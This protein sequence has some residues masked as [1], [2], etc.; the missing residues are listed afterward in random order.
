LIAAC[1]DVGKVSPGFQ[2]KYFADTVVARYAPSLVGRIGF[3]DL[4]ADIGA[5]A[6]DKYL[7]ASLPGSPA[8]KAIAAHHGTS[9]RVYL[10]DTAEPLG[11]QLWSE[12]RQRLLR[13]LREIFEGELEETTDTQLLSGLVCVSDWIGSSEEFFPS[14]RASALSA[15]SASSARLA[16]AQCGFRKFGFLK[17]LSFEQV[18][19]FAPR[20]AQRDFFENI[21]KPG[22]YILEAPM[23]IGKT[24]AALYA[25][26]KLM[27][28]GYNHGLYFA[29]P[30]RLTSDRIHER[31]AEFLKSIVDSNTPPE[32]LLAH[33]AAW[34]RSYEHGGVELS[35]G[36][37]WFFPAKRAL[38]HP[39]AVG[40]L[41]QALLG[42][43][44]VRHNF[45][46]LFGLAGKVVILDEVHSYDVY[47]GTLLDELTKRLREIGC[48][49]IILSATLTHHR[50]LAIAP[51][52]QVLPM[53]NLAESYPL[54]STS[55]QD[56]PVQYKPLP[57]PES[58]TYT[59]R[60]A[61]WDASALADF[62]IE[63]AQRGACVVCI[64]NTVAKAQIWYKTI[65]ATLRENAFPIGILHS[66]FPQ[67]RREEI[68]S[69]W[70]TRL[71]R[72]SAMRPRGAIMVATQ[73][74]E[75]SVDI[76]A[77]LMITE[78]APTD[79]ILQRMG[80]LWRHKRSNRPTAGPE[81]IIISRRPEQTAEVSEII[82]EIGA[83]NC[84]VYS[85]YI[86]MRSLAV[87][88]SRDT[89]TLPND[90]RPLI[91]ATYS[92]CHEEPGSSMY[93]LKEML[94]DQAR[95]LRSLAS[96]AQSSAFPAAS[97]R[98]E[99]RTRYS[100][101]PTVT[102]LLLEAI[103]SE[104]GSEDTAL[105]R[106]LDGTELSLNEYQRNLSSTRTLH[107]W[108]VSI[109][110]YLLAAPNWKPP[111]CRW[112]RRHFHEAPAVLIRDSDSA[113][114]FF[115]NG[116]ETKLYYSD[117]YGICRAENQERVVSSTQTGKTCCPELGD[118]DF[119]DPFTS[120]W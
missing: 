33:G 30:T 3:N 95:R 29:L 87:W 116:A 52:F 73:V 17:N 59:S 79:M 69:E 7:G 81:C 82:E 11:G 110:K 26:Y 99:G 15:D 67:I 84:R 21:Q 39:F 41:D 103:V 45:V 119:F 75:Q 36:S 101:L 28:A 12:E 72:D 70:L 32:A 76:D 93:R 46:R 50:R 18:F 55:V 96:G 24:E 90:M 53:D 102:V 107:R 66:R 20:P 37:S 34:L 25:A 35:A 42:V 94:L 78:L 44:N 65:A 89:A 43:L 114:L 112:L 16:L 8:A 83:A 106:L 31:V 98:E 57:A 4:H 40:T 56:R 14:D 108:T 80:R 64:A 13:R 61:D 120:D 104:S 23:G 22:I 62:A 49:V 85:P 113:R 88:Q 58:Q 63:A 97:D 47:T 77:D 115:P 100:D 74:L 19:G 105:V 118:D 86:L 54:L 48:T 6:M 9:N 111:V 38:L 2:L 71:G 91:E 51:Q 10:P 5:A 1:H 27:S 92:E 117:E 68:E 60:I 109:A